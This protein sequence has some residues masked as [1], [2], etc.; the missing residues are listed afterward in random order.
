MSDIRSSIII[1]VFSTA[2]GIGK[3]FVATNLAAE[4]S[5]Q[6]YAVCLMDLDLQFGDISSYLKLPQWENLAD[7]Q[8]D[9]NSN[10]LSFS[11][12]KFLSEYRHGSYAFSVMQPPAN[13]SDAYH[14]QPD[15][16]VS[17]IK[18]LNYF[19]FIVI[20][21]A[22]TLNELNLAVLDISTIITFICTINFIPTIKNLKIGYETLQRFN[23]DENKI[24]LV[25]NRSQSD[26]YIK[27][28]DVEKI[29]GKP[30]LHNIPNDFFSARRSIQNGVPIVFEDEPTNLS[31]SMQGLADRYTNKQTVELEDVQDIGFLARIFNF[32]SRLKTG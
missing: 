15:V 7:A 12:R 22:S 1:T 11:A 16:I 19:D 25:Q 28:S 24:W 4:L 10:P 30:F 2:S 9:Y 29:L 17:I 20:D 3:T 23:Y 5:R 18:N 13:L 32:F 31:R 21:T 27:T 14:I 8:R 26:K 6:G